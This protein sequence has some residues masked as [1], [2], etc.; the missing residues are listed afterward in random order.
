[1]YTGVNLRRDS[2]TPVI[3][4]DGLTWSFHIVTKLTEAEGAQ[5]R[6]RRRAIVCISVIMSV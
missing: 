6:E 4:R 5:R 3:Q 1:M 2:F